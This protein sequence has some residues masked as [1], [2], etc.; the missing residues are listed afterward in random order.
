MKIVK[1]SWSFVDHMKGSSVE[2]TL[3][4]KLLR[5]IIEQAGRL[6]YKSED[7]ITED[8][9][10][11]FVKKAIDIGH[12]SIIEHG[13]ISIRIITDRGMTH[14]LVRHRLASYSQES[15]RYCNYSNDKFGNEITVILPVWFED[16]DEKEVN[17]IV[18]NNT[19]LSNRQCQFT[20]WRAGCR[21]DENTYFSLLKV[22]A[23]PQEARDNLPNSLKTE[24]IMTANP[25]EWR[26]IFT[27]RT[28][29]KAHPQIRELML[30]ML[31][32]F[33]NVF[34]VLFDDIGE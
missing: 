26:H 4:E 2:S 8:S 3:G 15:T 34:P 33:K 12:H 21:S 9:A 11:E 30:D 19:G 14:E 6:C 17:T 1:Q 7:K 5:N 25:R 32:T 28:S 29:S 27:L 13:A 31:D 24:I 18:L 22:G 20:I 16:I 10:K 23:A